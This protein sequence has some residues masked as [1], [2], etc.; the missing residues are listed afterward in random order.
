MRNR[1]YDPDAGRFTQEDPIGLAGGINLYGFAEGDPVNFADPFG[2]CPPKTRNEVFLCAGQ[3]LKPAQLPLEIAGTAATLPLAAS[4]EAALVT[5]SIGTRLAA[6]AKQIH[7]A[8][9]A[10][11]QARTTV[12]V[13]R[14]INPDG[15][16][17]LLV[18]SSEKVLRP[19]QRAILRA[20]EQAVSGVGHAEETILHAAR[21]A[22]Q[23]VRSIAASRPICQRCA[24]AIREAGAHA[25]SAVKP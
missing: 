17:S 22:G 15:S 18:A 9:S 5:L 25:A 3:L 20:G 2:L 19:A 14:V 13:A 23:I 10:A 24:E 21:A 12:A 11:T 8:V 16:T 6:R 1:Y 4:G 7:A